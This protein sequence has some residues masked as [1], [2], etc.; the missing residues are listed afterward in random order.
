M[1]A[2]LEVPAEFYG[3]RLTC[4]KVTARDLALAGLE[5]DEI[6]QALKYE[7]VRQTRAPGDPAT[8]WQRETLGRLL[9]TSYT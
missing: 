7:L 5:G 2:T 3:R 6:G 9:R 8:P 1:D 4:T